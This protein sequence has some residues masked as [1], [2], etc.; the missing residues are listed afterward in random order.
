MEEFCSGLEC[1]AN[2]SN[3]AP[4]VA[5]NNNDPRCSPYRSYHFVLQ[6][7]LECHTPDTSEKALFLQNKNTPPDLTVNT[8]ES[9][10]YPFVHQRSQLTRE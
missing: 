2:G 3:I 4:S 5:G 6:F 9:C 7:W 1:V 8:S 10:L